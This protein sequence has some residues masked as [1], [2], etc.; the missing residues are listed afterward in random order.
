MSRKAAASD[1]EM[2][3][4]IELLSSSDED[5]NDN[6]AKPAAAVRPKP[7]RAAGSKVSSTQGLAKTNNQRN[8]GKTKTAQAS[9]R[10]PLQA[11]LVLEEDVD[12]CVQEGEIFHKMNDTKNSNAAKAKD[13]SSDSDINS[14][15]WTLASYIKHQEERKRQGQAVE[16]FHDLAF[17]STPASIEGQARQNKVEKC[18]CTAAQ[19]SAQPVA[20]SYITRGPNKGRPY[21]HCPKA[22][23]SARCKYFRWAFQAERM[24]WYRFGSHTG[25]V[26]VRDGGFSA[27]DLLQGRVGDCWFLS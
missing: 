9:A 21:H 26:L 18:R 23:K 19:G 11:G 16:L 12:E 24:H 6:D 4:V 27:D 2:N 7:A 20:L 22:I 5:E 13:E 3:D 1:D 14:N 17:E 10:L 15:N 8:R 25:H